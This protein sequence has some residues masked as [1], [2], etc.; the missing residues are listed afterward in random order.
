MPLLLRH[1]PAVRLDIA[2]VPRPLRILSG[3]A[4]EMTA[5][6]ALG[7]LEPADRSSDQ[8]PFRLRQLGP[9]LP[10]NGQQLLLVLLK[11]VAP[12]RRGPLRGS[13]WVLSLPCRSL[14]HADECH[15]FFSKKRTL[16]HKVCGHK[17]GRRGIFRG[18]QGRC[19]WHECSRHSLTLCHKVY[20]LAAGRQ[21]R[22]FGVKLGS[23]CLPICRRPSGGS[24][25]MPPSSSGK[26]ARSTSPW[27]A[28][29][30]ID[31]DFATRCATSPA[32]SRRTALVFPRED[33]SPL[34]QYVDSHQSPC[35]WRRR[36][37]KRRIH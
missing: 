25:S 7:L 23:C 36:G 20:R 2:P 24:P 9:S 31:N 34:P 21:V 28:P 6:H 10:R 11:I 15:N 27:R 37:D 17:A 16:H 1:E 29:A 32:G 22:I 4:K 35:S 14:K 12:G 18:R 30:F 33:R 8:V 13:A 3:A 26:A 19:A 5:L